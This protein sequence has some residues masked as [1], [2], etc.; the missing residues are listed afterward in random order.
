MK[1]RDTGCTFFSVGKTEKK[2]KNYT[3]PETIPE[4]NPN[5][6]KAGNEHTL[7]LNCDML[8]RLLVTGEI[9]VYCE[10]H[11]KHRRPKSTTRDV[12]PSYHER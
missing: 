10:S 1:V 9:K 7:N 4:R 12:I 3:I 2:T 6:K 8:H 5:E 11:R